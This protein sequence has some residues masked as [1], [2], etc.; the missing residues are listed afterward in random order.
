MVGGE[1]GMCGREGWEERGGEG[2]DLKRSL[3][4]SFRPVGQNCNRSTGGYSLPPSL[5]PWGLRGKRFL[6]L[7]ITF[8]TFEI[9]D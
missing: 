4:L 1:E 6:R 7:T 8:E 3:S 9:V 2:W 5:T